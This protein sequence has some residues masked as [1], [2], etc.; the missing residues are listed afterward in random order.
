MI[1]RLLCALGFHRD[2]GLQFLR[3]DGYTLVSTVCSECPWVSKGVEF[4]SRRLS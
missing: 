4:P 2:G 3:R 1:R